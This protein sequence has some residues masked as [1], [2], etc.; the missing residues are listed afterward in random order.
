MT[1]EPAFGVPV[2]LTV[3]YEQQCGHRVYASEPWI[4]D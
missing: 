4:S 2:G 1:L 3:S